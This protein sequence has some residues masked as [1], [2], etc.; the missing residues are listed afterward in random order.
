MSFSVTRDGASAPFFDATAEG[1]LLIRRC[2]ACG[3]A[4]PAQARRCTDSDEL[5]WEDASGDAVLITWAVDH[6]TPLDPVLGSPD[7]LTSTVGI[8]ELTESPWLQVPIVG[9]DPATL[10]EGTPMRVQF[11]RPGDGEAIPAFSPAS[12]Q[13]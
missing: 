11:V 8:V 9:A 3:T 12:V 7:G 10:T 1:R 6:S 13:R 5:E 4:H 2:P